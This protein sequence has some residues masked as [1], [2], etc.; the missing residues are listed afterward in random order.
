MTVA[1]NHVHNTHIQLTK[2]FS[3]MIFV[4]RHNA[5]HI[6]RALVVNFV[7]YVQTWFYCKVRRFR[8]SFGKI[9]KG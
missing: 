5:I 7:S 6:L 3:R 4:Q 9:S 1:Q 8:K 2:Q